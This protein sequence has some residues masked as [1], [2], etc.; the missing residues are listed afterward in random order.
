MA[1]FCV[2]KTYI[3]EYYNNNMAQIQR[4]GGIPQKDVFFKKVQTKK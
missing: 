2:E 4:C 1:G 3:F